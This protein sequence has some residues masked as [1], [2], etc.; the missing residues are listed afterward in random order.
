[1]RRITSICFVL[2]FL[3]LS[4]GSFANGENIVWPDLPTTGFL[5]GRTATVDD[6]KNGNAVFSM[7]GQSAGVLPLTIPQ[8]VEWTDENGQKHPMILVQA[9]KGPDGTEIVG[10]RDFQGKDTVAT[11]PELTLLGTKKPN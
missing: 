3:T 11:L 10:L 9:E 6:A 4:S 2:A 1:M 8:Y 7:N 5:N